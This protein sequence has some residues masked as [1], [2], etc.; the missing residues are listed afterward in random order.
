[1]KPLNRVLILYLSIGSGHQSAANALKDGFQRNDPD[2]AVSCEDLFTPEIQNSII[3]E[4]LSLNSTIFFSRLYDEAWQTGSMLQGY[5]IIKSSSLLRNRI[6]DLIIK[7]NPQ[8]VIC[9]H[10]LP[11]SVSTKLL[12]EGFDIPPVFAVAT[13]FLVHPYWPVEGLEGFVVSTSE[14]K[15]ILI[16]R[17]M[18]TEKIRTFGIPVNPAVESMSHK[19]DEIPN[20]SQLSTIQ[21]PFQVLILAG[22]KRLAPYVAIWP[23]TLN[24]LTESIK[25]PSGS[26]QWNV[27]YGKPSI[28][29]KLLMDSTAGREDIQLLEYVP[30]FITFLKDQYLVIAK[31]G[32]LI[33]AECAAIGKPV[34]LV[35]RGSGQES[36]NSNVFI[37]AGAGFYLR[38]EKAVIDKVQHFVENPT[39]Y[40]KAVKAASELGNPDATRR[41]V[42][43][44]VETCT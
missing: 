31:P 34:I 8:V 32:G 41:I 10:T 19:T 6:L 44:I 17:G 40:Q 30:D 20:L 23:R 39:D 4:F 9:T 3:P 29:S 37:S 15:S 18:P 28:F 25:L 38:D 14:A 12:Q 21:K 27:V 5:E 7:K 33:L 2:C 11:C 16:Q 24:L 22:G 35:H 13:D 36:A 1:M 43:W 42:E 26:I